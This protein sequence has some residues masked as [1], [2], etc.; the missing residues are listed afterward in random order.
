MSLEQ[1]KLESMFADKTG[2]WERYAKLTDLDVFKACSFTQLRKSIRVNTIKAKVAD[3]RK[4]LSD[5]WRLTPVPWCNE[6][7]WI[8][9]ERRDIGNLAEHVLGYIYVQE[10]ASMI[11]PVVLDPRPGD[12]VLDLCAAPGSK[13]TQ[14]AAMMQNEG[15]IVANDVNY[16]RLASLG[17]NVQRMGCTNVMLTNMQGQ[18]FKKCKL[19]FDR[20]LV[21]APCS[22]TGTIRKSFRTLD[23]W[24]PKLVT[25]L[26]ETQKSLLR[27]AWQ[28]LAPGG[29]L[30]YSTCTMEPQEDEG[31]VSWFLG[32]HGDASIQDIRFDE[33][34]SGP[35]MAFEGERYCNT[36]KKCLRIWPQDNDSEGFF[37]A[38]F[39]K[40]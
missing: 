21:D 28:A 39:V 9:G 4:R 15:L 14:M 16:N 29:T 40:R 2:F 6:G 17:I 30:V 24:S 22:G 10:A 33:K 7:F 12:L 11:P 19:R 18:Q 20:I 36:V 26:A 3:I 32:A 31:I 8:E 23:D 38:K 37:V 34:R 25:R 13:T 5:D 1:E 27:T 35:V